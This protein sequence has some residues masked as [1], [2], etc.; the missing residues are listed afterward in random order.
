MAFYLQELP[1]RTAGD[2]QRHHHESVHIVTAGR[3]FSEIGEETVRSTEGDLVYTP[4]W[5]W[6]RHYNDGDDAVRMVLVENSRLLEA[7]GIGERQSAGEI[8]FRDLR[9]GVAEATRGHVAS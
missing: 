7:L 5:V 6:H 1:P 3:G 9:N 2:L 8:A 4:P